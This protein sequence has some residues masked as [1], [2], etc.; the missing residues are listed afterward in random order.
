MTL[1]T[2]NSSLKKMFSRRINIPRL[3][4]GSYFID[5]DPDIFFYILQYLRNKI[6]ILDDF[7]QSKLHKLLHVA[8]SFRID[9]LSYAVQNRISAPP[10]LSW[11]DPSD[12]GIREIPGSNIVFLLSK[13]TY[14]DF[15]VKYDLPHGLIWATMSEF[16]MEYERSRV[17]I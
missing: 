10:D 15:D 1:T 16:A 8:K 17:F 6:V 12:Q 11:L 4:D 2:C 5:S 9:S 7:S 14:W 3:E 13:D